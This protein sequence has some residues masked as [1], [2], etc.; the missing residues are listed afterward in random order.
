MDYLVSKHI[1]DNTPIDKKEL[2]STAFDELSKIYKEN[3][4]LSG[5]DLDIANYVKN[6][7]YRLL[8]HMLINQSAKDQKRHYYIRNYIIK[9]FFQIVKLLP[10]PQIKFEIIQISYELINNLKNRD[11]ACREHAREGIRILLGSV[12]MF[13]STFLFHELKAQLHSGY[14]RYIM[15]YTCNY[16]INLI[17]SC[18]ND[19]DSRLIFN[20]SVLNIIPILLDELFGAVSEE[21]EVE[22]LVRKYKEAKSTKAYNSFFVVS[23]KIDFK[24]G[25]LHMINPL[26]EF[27]KTREN[28]ATVINKSNEVL[29]NM[30]KGFKNNSTINFDDV[31]VLSLSLISLGIDLNLKNSKI[32]RENR[33]LTIKGDLA[34]GD[35]MIVDHLNQMDKTF[36]VQVG[37]ANC[38]SYQ[39]VVSNKFL[40]EKN[41]IIISN[42]FTQLGLDIFFIIIKKKLFDFELIKNEEYQNTENVEKISLLLQYVVSCLKISN[43]NILVKAVKI[44][45]NIFD[46]KLPIIKKNL[47]KIVSA[48]FKNLN[49]INSADYNVAQTLLSSIS[50][51]LIKFTFYEITQNQVKLLTDF[52]KINIDN[53]HIKPYV[54]SCILSLVK[55]KINLPAIYDLINL[56]QETYLTAFEENSIV[57]CQNVIYHNLD[58]Y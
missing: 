58:H 56:V 29:N 54:F 11:H 28:D 55:R 23:S 6:N 14:Q 3:K 4:N 8:K 18:S 17:N 27:L 57:V 53:S 7:I 45:M 41:E 35:K 25:I 47:R 48:L 20:I 42:L 19:E 9:P 22:Q 39:I 34:N 32:I 44:L 30:V 24:M 15:G 46:A 21:M 51:V 1:N 10:P 43:N 12:S 36:T 13:I 38:G 31:I 26:K 33:K 37:A 16:I 50:E 52:L 2:I 49:M 5:I 40:Q